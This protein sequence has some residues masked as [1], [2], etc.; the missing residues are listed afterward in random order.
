MARR[1]NRVAID[2]HVAAV[3]ITVVAFEQVDMWIAQMSCS[4]NTW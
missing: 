3:A 2:L 4:A 1:Q